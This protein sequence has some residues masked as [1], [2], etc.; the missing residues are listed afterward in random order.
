MKFI[1]ARALRLAVLLPAIVLAA[2]AHADAVAASRFYED[3]LARYEKRDLPGAVI[4]LK[5][6]LQQDRDMLSAH[7]LLAR[8]YFDQSEVGLAEVEFR[9]ALRLG[10][11]RAEVA[12]P[13]GRILLMRGKPQAVL[14]S[15]PAE[16]LSAAVRLEVLSLRGTAYATLGKSSEASRSFAEARAIDAGSIVPLVAE[17]PVLLAAGSIDAARGLA[18]RAV[19]LAPRDAAAFNA[20]ASVA[21]AAGE[22]RSALQD[23]ERAISFEPGHFD[24]RVARAGILID[25]ARDDEARRD[26]EE[27]A[28]TGPAEPRVAYLRALL[29]SR[30]GDPVAAGTHLQEVARLVDALPAEWIAGQEQLLMAGALAHHAGRQYEKARKYLDVLVIRYPRNQGARKL[31]AA[32]YIDTGDHARAVTVLENV[33]RAQPDDPQALHLLGRSHLA[34]KRYAKAIELLEKAETLAAG[35]PG[36]QASLGFSRLGGGNREAAIANLRSAYDRAP[37]DLGLAVTLGNLYMRQGERQ[38]A[39]EVAQRAVAVLPGNPA[40]LNLL[41]LIRAASGDLSGARRAYADAIRSDAAFV[42]A[43]LNL[44]R[45][46]AGEGRFDA[47]RAVYA[48]LLQKNKRDATVMYEAALLEQRAG[49]KAEALRWI[50]KAAAE[51]PNDLPIGLAQVDLRAANGDKAGAREAARALSLRRSGDLVVLAALA[52]AEIEAGELKSARQTLRNMTRLADFDAAALVRIG[53]LQL[54]AS[55]PEGAVYSAQKALQGSPGDPAARVLAIEAA[56]AQR[57]LQAAAEQLRLLR[58][59]HP[60]DVDGLRLAGNLAM[61]RKQY[62]A[63]ADFHRQVLERKPGIDALTRY[64]RVFVQQGNPS[65]AIPVVQGWLKQHDDDVAARAM[66]GELFMRVANWRAAKAEYERLAA[67]NSADFATYNNLANVLIELKDGAAIQAAQ[68]AVAIAPGNVGALDT[69]GWAL[70]RSG[71]FDEA[72]RYLRDARLRAPTDAEVRWH[73]A[74]VLAKLGRKEEAS[75]ELGIALKSGASAPWVREAEA[76]ARTL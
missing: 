73:L 63:A 25:L 15:I 36:V 22:L 44:A 12:V 4:Q 52:R 72:I 49:R 38:K 60:A 61:E 16:G 45:V 26:V 32:V 23:Y 69:L 46:D 59:A 28:R 18:G 10:V 48:E 41:G 47:A 62:A 53:Y 43:R 2:P 31:L 29:A 75:S 70:A 24:A 66:L 56:I 17:V 11:N 3:A 74:Y 64:V 50:E 13:L 71:R 40:A 67:D 30:R 5:N 14:E 27:L 33:L 57:D 58:A 20:R 7:L 34:Q 51:R 8:A 65:G 35:D 68:K 21:H 54:A 42:P 6:A 9:E 1:F 76:L 19:Q 37:A 55:N 39:L